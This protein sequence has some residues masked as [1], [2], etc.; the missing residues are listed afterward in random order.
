MA[1]HAIQRAGLCLI[2][3]RCFGVLAAYDA[4]DTDVLH[5][6][7]D[8][9]AGYIKALPPYLMPDLPHAI[10]AEVILKDPLDLGRQISITLRTV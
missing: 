4:L 6:S 10:D 8:R 7:G 2:L 1:V 3:D 5:Q 9:A